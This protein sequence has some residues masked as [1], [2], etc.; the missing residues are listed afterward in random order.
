[1]GRFCYPTKQNVIGLY[2]YMSW[3]NSN[4]MWQKVGEGYMVIGKPD[5]PQSRIKNLLT[6]MVIYN[7]NPVPIRIKYLV[8]A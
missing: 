1:M 2:K 4:K 8:F 3:V 5:E 7:P 6:S